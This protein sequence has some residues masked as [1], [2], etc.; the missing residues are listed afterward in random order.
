MAAGDLQALS[1]GLHPGTSRSEVS[2]R[3][4]A[5]SRSTAQVP[6]ELAVADVRLEPEI[7]AAIYFLCAEGLANMAKHAGAFQVRIAIRLRRAR[8][9]PSSCVTTASA[10]PTS[11]AARDFAG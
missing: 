2:P 3:H 1:R 7:E 5:G 9:S 8:S 10:A 11:R 6:I 4:F